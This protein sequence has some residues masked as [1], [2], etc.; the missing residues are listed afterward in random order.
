MT[1]YIGGALRAFQSLIPLTQKVVV[2][3]TSLP[4]LCIAMVVGYIASAVAILA[5]AHM[6]LSAV[7]A[8]DVFSGLFAGAMLLHHYRVIEFGAAE[9]AVD[10]VKR[11]QL[12][13]TQ[14]T[15]PK[16]VVREEEA[17]ARVPVPHVVGSTQIPAPTLSN[18]DSASRTQ[19]GSPST[20][21]RTRASS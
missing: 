8:L 18:D 4:A 15:E 6:A 13:S 10:E 12:G 5:Q 20:T 21:L 3:L 2:V 17:R 11:T 14:L 7:S 9:I 1:P 19:R 16:V